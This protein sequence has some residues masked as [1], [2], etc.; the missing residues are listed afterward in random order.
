MEPSY[1]ILDGK[2]ACLEVAELVNQRRHL[3]TDGDGVNDSRDSLLHVHAFEVERG[4]CVSHIVSLG[5]K[6]D[7]LDSLRRERMLFDGLQDLLVHRGYGH[8]ERIGASS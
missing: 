5:Q 6:D 7:L 2:L 3:T 1:L 8:T 4:L